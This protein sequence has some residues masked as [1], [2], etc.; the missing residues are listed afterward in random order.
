MDSRFFR[1][2]ITNDLLQH[3]INADWEKEEKI[4][5]VHSDLIFQTA[6]VKDINGYEITTSPI[7]YALRVNDIFTITM[8]KK[9]FSDAQQKQFEELIAHHP[10]FTEPS[11]S[12]ARSDFIMMIYHN[13][14]LNQMREFLREQTKPDPSSNACFNLQPFF[15]VY[16]ALCNMDI[17]S[18][19]YW[20]DIVGW[21]QWNL[22]PRHMLKQMCAGSGP[23]EWPLGY[24]NDRDSGLAWSPTASFANTD[25]K[26]PLH[27]DDHRREGHHHGGDHM[28]IF[29]GNND[30]PGN[31]YALVRNVDS[32]ITAANDHHFTSSE[33]DMGILKTFQHLAAVRHQQVKQSGPGLL[34]QLYRGVAAWF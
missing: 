26:M 1:S 14:P 15:W 21:A 19:E 34:T 10:E 16:E 23:C 33:S 12:S 29:N 30:V 13:V 4:V 6:S 9:Y 24:A 18:D 28:D 22:L 31:G 32:Y 27:I 17:T 20:S 2:H 5:K 8:F 11:Q 3:V 25:W 7:Q